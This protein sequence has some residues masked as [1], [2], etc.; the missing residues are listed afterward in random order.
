M[1][2]DGAASAHEVAFFPLRNRR[3]S[4]SSRDIAIRAKGNPSNT[5]GSPTAAFP[6][7]PIPATPGFLLGPE[8]QAA[9]LF[10]QTLLAESGACKVTRAT[11]GLEK[12]TQFTLLI[13]PPQSGKSHLAFGLADAWQAARPKDKAVAISGTEWNQTIGRA[14]R[15]KNLDRLREAWR[16]ISLLVIDDIEPLAR[17]EF[18][19]EELV[20]VIQ[21]LLD[22]DARIVLTCQSISHLAE[23]FGTRLRARLL[24]ALWV[25]LKP[26]ALV[27]QQHL[28][29]HWDK[30]L[31]F[32]RHPQRTHTIQKS[33]DVARTSIQ[34]P[35]N[36]P[37]VAQLQRYLPAA[38]IPELWD[39]YQAASRGELAPLNVLSQGKRPASRRSQADRRPGNALPLRK[40]AQRTSRS[41]EVPISQMRGP[42]RRQ[43]VVNARAAAVL[44][45]RQLTDSSFESIGRYFGGRDHTTAMHSFRQAQR[46][47]QT[48]TAF[49]QIVDQLATELQ[50]AR[51]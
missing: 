1:N 48:N 6:Q 3:R 33:D 35:V 25:T 45:A 4:A 13:G 8:N 31:A 51:R 30:A 28:L 38:N 11:D 39:L 46:L 43:V 21:D 40:I 24:S 23:G 9:V 5:S 50:G 18:S 17:R 32:E 47:Q 15:Q 7:R 19:Q 37:A 36:K 27:T 20:Q 2:L 22:Q 16:S 26:A 12:L 14:V 49:R 10:L 44:L 42:T 34:Q 41:F 29:A